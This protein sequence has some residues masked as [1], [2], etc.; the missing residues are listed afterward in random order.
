MTHVFQTILL[1]LFCLAPPA[2]FAAEKTT[3]RRHDDWTTIRV[4]TGRDALCKATT[5]SGKK[6]LV[7]DRFTDS[8]NLYIRLLLESQSV[9]GILTVS[10]DG[11]R[12]AELAPALDYL[13]QNGE[14]I[15]KGDQVVFQLIDSF[16][17]GKKVTLES[18][19]SSGETQQIAT[20]SLFGFASA[21]ADMKQADSTLKT[22][23]K[24]ELGPA[25]RDAA[26]KGDAERVKA[27]LADRADPNS[28]DT[29]W[30]TALHEACFHGHAQVV[31]IL[32]SSGAK[33]EESD[34]FTKAKPIHDAAYSGSAPIV[35][36]LAKKGAEINARADSNQTALHVA[37]EGGHEEVVRALIELRANT[38]LKDDEGRTALDLARKKGHAK[39]VSLLEK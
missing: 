25:L 39:I 14:Y 21:F 12:T 8:G 20:F 27:L 23:T 3:T 19:A 13:R 22:A 30:R 5:E 9:S 6:V 10:V 1:T 4:G 32:L 26:V 16:K 34:I 31:E 17:S 7:L 37:A 29:I 11:K 28:H 33:V 36:M 18:R 24:A 38:G 15:I 35:R 2:T